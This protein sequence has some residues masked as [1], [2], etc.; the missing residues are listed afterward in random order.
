MTG[1]YEQPKVLT[2]D[3]KEILKCILNTNPEKRFKVSD[4]R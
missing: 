2:S 1:E 4:I 3:S